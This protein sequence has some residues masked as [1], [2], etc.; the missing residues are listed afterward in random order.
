MNSIETN[1]KIDQVMINVFK[2]LKNNRYE[3][4]VRES[5]RCAGF[6]ECCLQ[7]K[8]VIETGAKDAFKPY[9]NEKDFKIF[10][11]K[12]GTEKRSYVEVIQTICEE[13]FS[14]NGISIEE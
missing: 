3:A 13:Y 1:F 11:F 4:N 2:D 5:I 12:I 6:L 9:E 10:G 14:T 7:I 8:G